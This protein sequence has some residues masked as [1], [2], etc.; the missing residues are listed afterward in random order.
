MNLKKIY[1]FLIIGLITIPVFIHGIDDDTFLDEMDNPSHLFSNVEQEHLSASDGRECCFPLPNIGTEDAENL[2]DFLTLLVNANIPQ[3][4]TK[5]FFLGTNPVQSRSLLDLPSTGLDLTIND[6]HCHQLLINAFYNQTTKMKYRCNSPCIGSYLNITSKDILEDL[7]E[8]ILDSFGLNTDDVLDL[9][10]RANPFSLQQRRAG[11]M[12]NY[13]R[14][15]GRGTFGLNVPFYYFER[16]FFL[17]EK[18]QAVIADAPVFQQFGPLSSDEDTLLQYGYKNMLSDQIGF[19][20]IRFNGYY[21]FKDTDKQYATIGAVLTLPTAFALAKHVFG[22]KYCKTKPRPLFD[23]VTVA[24]YVPPTDEQATLLKNMFFE[25]ST[26]VLHQLTANLAYTS[27]GNYHHVTFGPR[28]EYNYKIRPHWAVKLYTDIQYFCP[29]KEPRFYIPVKD[30]AE[31]SDAVRDYENV[32][33]AEENLLFLSRQITDF[34]F[35]KCITTK[36]SPG[37]LV[38][39]SAATWFKTKRTNIELGYNFWRQS[40]EKITLDCKPAIPYYVCKGVKSGAYQNKLY[41]RF[42]LKIPERCGGLH[43]GIYGD[44]TFQSFNIGKD[45]TLAV[46]TE[47]YY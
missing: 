20:D 26:C 17:S 28:F 45:F 13:N 35:P 1:S 29:A 40:T 43:I 33:L 39:L 34:L 47:F 30:P 21:T 36:V 18:E 9:M 3:V 44:Y 2:L 46:N 10:L 8:S 7:D 5:N 41:A 42:L 38:N 23:L 27:L 12:I 14:R 32:N 19:G 11:F 6:D 22:G 15:W 16:N 37:F 24:S 4:L 31:F 25:Y